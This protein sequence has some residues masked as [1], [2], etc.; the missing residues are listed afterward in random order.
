MS[1][2]PAVFDQEWSRTWHQSEEIPEQLRQHL[3]MI[4][5]GYRYNNYLSTFKRIHK[6]L[7]GTAL[8][9]IATSSPGSLFVLEEYFSAVLTAPSYS[10]RIIL[11]WKTLVMS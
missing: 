3:S 10:F 9:N 7:H 4:C 11:C 2:L 5:T 1:P 8:A 6:S